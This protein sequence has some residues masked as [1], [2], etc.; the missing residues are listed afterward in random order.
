MAMIY[1][2]H[3]A[4]TPLR[5]EVLAAMEPYY[6]STDQGDS[7]KYG[8]P[9]SI[10]RAGRAAHAG[11]SEARHTIAD[12]L[13]VNPNEIVFTGCGSESDN[14]ALRG[15]ALARR[16]QHGANRI[17]TTPVEH[18]AV[19]YTAEDLRDCFGFELTLLPVDCD[20]LVSADDLDRALGDGS[21]VAVVSVMYANNEIGSVQAIGEFGALCR[22]RK[23]PFHTDAV[24]AA[25][26]L[27]L[28]VNEL[29][30]DALSAS[31]HK[32]YGPKGVGF[33]YLRRGTP[34][35]P[36]LTGGSHEGRRRAG[37]QNVP[38]IVG[39]ATALALCEAEREA[40]MARLRQLRDRIIGHTLESVE[41]ARLTGSP[42]N[43]LANHASFTVRDVEAEGIL[44][45]LDLAGIAASSGS[46]CTSAR[47]QPSHVLE[48]VGVPVDE[49]AGGLRLSL[50]LSNNAEQVD[51]LLEK[52]PQ[53]VDRHRQISPAPL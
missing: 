49:L 21:D 8:N 30:V 36:F 2:D 48:A 14:A 12:V 35:H 40:E 42:T 17:I 24:Q 1:L 50:G 41:G 7:S 46:A 34:F 47:Q 13:G 22:E 23:A 4:T 43:R 53:I 45:A 3:S 38:G 16:T 37:T 20:G 9:S 27:P 33:L 32:F 5:P 26:K 6:G 52:L 44:I 10:H 39:M 29:N 18:H 15:I 28:D 31:A 25:G 19:L 51:F 11:L